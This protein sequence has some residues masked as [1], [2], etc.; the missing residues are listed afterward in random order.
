MKNQIPRGFR[1]LLPE[2]VEAEKKVIDKIRAVFEKSNYERVITPTLEYVE[3]LT[4]GLSADLQKE[5]FKFFDGEGQPVMLRPE[6]TTPIARLVSTRNQNVTKPI[7]YFYSGDV[8]RNTQLNLGFPS[9]FHQ[10]GLELIGVKGTAG[11]LE[12]IDLAKKSLMAVGLKNVQV[13]IG[14]AAKIS[15]KSKKDQ[16]HLLNQDFV[17]LKNLPSKE[18]LVARNHDYYTGMIFQIYV[19]ELGYLIGSGGRYD[20][21][22]GKFG[23]SRPAVG[24]AFS[25]NRVLLALE[26]QK[27]KKS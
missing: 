16:D 12:V 11:D 14:D 23:Q 19:P 15:K 1:D 17:S 22:L 4:P 10:M 21:L 20:D 2:E 26:A 27:G 8:F 25:L 7:R 13:T 24:F 6:H 5:A 9:Q 18:D 3:A